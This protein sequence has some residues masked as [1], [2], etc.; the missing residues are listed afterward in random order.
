MLV[1]AGPGSGK[2][3]VLVHRM[4]YLIRVRRETPGGIL[5]LAYNRHAA[6]EIRRRLENLVG[7][8]ARGVTVLTC[9]ALAMRLAGSSFSAIAGQ[10]ENKMFREVVRRA[11][12]LLQ[13]TGLPPDEADE[14][15]ERLLAGFRWIL[16]DEYQDIEADQYDM[17]SALAGR[18]LKDDSGKLSLFAVGDDDQN[19]YAFNGSSVEFIRRFEK[20]YDAKPT[21]LTDN[22]RST[23][24]IVASA[25]AV[26]EPARNRMKRG[27]PIHVN[28]ARSS[29]PMGGEWQKLDPVA[30]GRVQVLPAG[31]DTVSQA[32]VAMGELLRL[33]ESVPDW[34][35]SRC[36][37]IARKWACLAPVR[38]FC[39]VHGIPTQMGNEEI[40]GFWWLRETR[41]LR[42][43]LRARQPSIVDGESLREWADALR[44]G[45]WTDL[46]RQ[47]VDE[48][49]LETGGAETPVEHFI[50]WLAEWGRDVRRRQSGLLLVTA[51]RAKGLEFDHVVI[52][53]GDWD[54]QSKG[55]DPDAPRRLYYVAMTRARETLTLMNIYE[56]N[57]LREAL[58][59]CQSVLRRQPLSLPQAGP[60]FPQAGPEL[61]CTY[62]R[63]RLEDVNL[64][65]AGHRQS[66]DKTHR[67]IAALSCG[68]PLDWRVSMNGRWE[69]L[70]RN[71]TMVGQMASKFP[72]AEVNTMR[73]RS[74]KVQAITGWSR[75]ASGPEFHNRIRC[76][77]W[78]VV[79][80]EFVFEPKGSQ[81][82]DS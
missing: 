61:H 66:K 32:R 7:E 1:L 77:S 64:G 34:D 30:K 31:P 42:E 16:V 52:L 65:F 54:R 21:Y 28:R 46:L 15:R 18:T 8:D 41:E 76:D 17:I 74:V 3:K 11:V 55:E 48:H 14:R 10:P 62:F 47:A 29:D 68:D 40:P 45:P 69:L 73:C 71:G 27:H 78:E 50:E 9:H 20:D 81:A 72:P 56:T 51:H 4:A 43:W 60:E 35:W 80:P 58:A 13:G 6:V 5:A 63:V 75:E 59:D 36:A 70:D 57:Q 49:A 82:D 26:I 12:D 67:A 33:A 23:A 22:Y 44:R 79:V 53:D 38:A 25:N 37:V 2:T 39:E 19:I 24:H